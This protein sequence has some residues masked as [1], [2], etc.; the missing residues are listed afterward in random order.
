[1]SSSIPAVTRTAPER[2]KL[3]CLAVRSLT[4]DESER[5]D[6]G[7]K[8]DG[9]VEV[10]D[11]APAGSLAEEA[12]EDD[13]GGAG[14]TGDGGPGSE[15]DVAVALVREGRHQDRERSR[16]HQRGADP[17]GEPRGD[18]HAV[19]VGGA[20]DERGEREQDQPGEEDAAAADEV[21]GAVRRAGGSRR[22]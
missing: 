21:G 15:R 18:E 22:R 11:P 5:A 7:E 6:A 12:A 14:E 19:V 1:M 9:H 17:L 10:E 13:A 4:R 2:S 20:G 8:R 3:L 16:G